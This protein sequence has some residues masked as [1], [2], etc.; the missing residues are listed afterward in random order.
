MVGH[1]W[2]HDAW[3]GLPERSRLVLRERLSGTTLGVIGRSFT[4]VL[5]RERVRQI[6]TEANEQLHRD[7]AW[8]APGLLLELARHVVANLVISTTDARDLIGTSSTDA[9]HALLTAN[10]YRRVTAP[11]TASDT[12]WSPRPTQ[13][14]ELLNRLCGLTPL[15]FSDA[16]AAAREIG[17]P[18]DLMWEDHLDEADAKITRHELGWVRRARLTRDV[19]Y[20]WLRA[21]GEPRTA[22]EVAEVVGCAEHTI[23]ES[24]RRDE[25]FAQVR[26]EGTW[27]LTDWRTPGAEQRYA[28]AVDVVVEVLRELGALDVD[29]LRVEVR[30]RYP[31]TDWRVQQCLSSNLIGLLPD[32]RYDLAERG[33]IPVEDDEP[34]QPP[35][36]KSV[37]AIV[38]VT[39]PVDRDLLRG[40]GLAVNRWLTWRLGLRTA[41]TSR[42]FAL[43]DGLGEVRVTRAVSTSQVSSLRLVAQH[44]HLVEGCTLALLLNTDNDSATVRHACASSDC[45][46]RA[47]HQ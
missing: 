21:E 12:Y 14:T 26:P 41:P 37:G 2:A 31:V 17:L 20:L 10:D 24:M 3:E 6:E 33:A 19:A 38:G 15:T 16:T 29:R 45:P 34:R 32:G 35:N 1:D 42:H 8:E 4:P 47:P 13:V 44:N 9:C 46:A 18:A 43:P 27:T 25:A 36:I 28:S 30:Q 7:Q 23:R 40:S 22:A 5:S 11:A 39:I